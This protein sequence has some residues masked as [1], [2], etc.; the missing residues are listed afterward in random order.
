M[1][2]LDKTERR[3]SNPHEMSANI[4]LS[5]NRQLRCDD[6]LSVPPRLHSATLHW[7]HT[8]ERGIVNHAQEN[9]VHAL[10]RSHEAAEVQGEEA[11]PEQDGGVG[12]GNSTA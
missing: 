9:I 10:R 12:S 4:K 5:W 1:A 7:Q 2:R 3:D 6:R 11:G 8:N